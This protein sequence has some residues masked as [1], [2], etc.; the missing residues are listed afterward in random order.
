MIN[1]SHRRGSW[2][3]LSGEFIREQWI[4]AAL[5]ASVGIGCAIVKELVADDVAFRDTIANEWTAV[6]NH[7]GFSGF[8]SYRP[9]GVTLIWLFCIVALLKA[10]PSILKAI[11]SWILGIVSGLFV[12]WA[13]SFFL[14]FSLASV[15]PLQQLVRALVIGLTLSIVSLMFRIRAVHASTLIPREISFALPKHGP[16]TILETNPSGLDAECPIVEWDQDVLNRSALVESL[17]TTVLVSRAPVVA[18]DGQFGD[19]KSSVMNLLKRTLRQHAIVIP[20]SAWLPGSEETLATDMFSD[21]AT[22]CKRLY[23]LPRLRRRLLAYAKTICGSISFLK[24][25]PELFPPVSQKDEIEEMGK[26]LSRIPRR[27]VVLLDEMDRLQ[28]GELQVVLKILRGVAFF[29]NLSYVCAFDRSVVMRT[30][31]GEHNLESREYFEKF[32]PVVFALPK[33]DANLLFQMLH[34]RLVAVFNESHMLQTDDEKKRFIKTLGELWDRTLISLCT[35][36]RKVVLIVNDVSVSVRP[37]AR[38]INALDLVSLEVLRRFFPSIYEQVWRNQEHFVEFRMSEKTVFYHTEETIQKERTAFFQLLQTNLDAT[39]QPKEAA[40]LLRWLF[41]AYAKYPMSSA[42]WTQRRREVD[43]EKAEKEKRIFHPDFFPVYFR[44]QVPETMFSQ[45]DL[46]RFV[47][48]MNSTSSL[49]AC[50]DYFSRTF[51][52]IPKQSPRRFDFLHRIGIS[53]NRFNDLQAEALAHAVAKHASE[54]VYDSIIFMA[55]EAGRA[56]V[57]VFEVAQRFSKSSKVQDILEASIANAADDTFAVRILELS[58]Q[59]RNK[60]LLDFSHV[61][62]DGLKEVFVK[63]MEHRYGPEAR[64]SDVKLAQGDRNA[65]VIWAKHSDTARGMEIQFWRQFV[66]HSQKRLV[67]AVDFIFPGN[68]LW[69]TDP[70]PHVDLL[71]PIEEFKE[72]LETSPQEGQLDENETRTLERLRELISGKFK[73]GVPFPWHPT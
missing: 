65:F 51:A 48:V 6:A 9:L 20:F 39:G 37:I 23:Y 22:E 63:R 40:D 19:G 69:E 25:V 64:M 54:Y 61:N 56:L 28:K 60:I 8:S 5:G 55:A 38:E 44:Y 27:I 53:E 59:D 68:V 11:K 3:A 13:A 42:K 49:K 7:P 45:A 26:A 2:L 46:E 12:C 24:A 70:T 4:K 62:A 18:I 66:D 50:I 31:F 10:L 71:F 16:R 41:P 35:N 32:F 43:D 67:Q 1:S 33:P 58:K 36:L 73:N 29:P 47:D 14:S 17:G 57:I 34:L 52:E 15:P 30:C 72:L 21:I